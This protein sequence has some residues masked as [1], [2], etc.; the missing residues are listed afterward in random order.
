MGMSCLVEVH[1]E[2]ELNIALDAGARIIGINN[3]DLDTL[4]ID[5]EMSFRLR[6]KIPSDVI[7]IS[8]SGIKTCF[9]MEKLKKKRFNGVLIGE[10]LM[11]S[12]NIGKAL[13]TLKGT[14]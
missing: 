9:E 8:E 6:D 12:E 2:S 4:Q 5:L 14:I 11:C 13:R 1:C 3:R 7:T 10:T